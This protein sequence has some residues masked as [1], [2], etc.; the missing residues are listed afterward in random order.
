MP[1]SLPF[2]SL[3]LAGTTVCLA[4]SGLFAGTAYADEPA[5][6]PAA[7]AHFETHI[8]PLLAKRC[9]ECHG[10]E[11]QQGGVRLDRRAT[12]FSQGEL[13]AGGP[14]IVPG[15]A[16]GSRLIEV[17]AHGDYDTGM[18][19]A[20]KLPADEIALLT[21]WIER[22][23]VWPADAA[24]SEDADRSN[25]WS[26]RPVERPPVPEVAGATPIDRFLNASLQ[27]A[28]VTP[29]PR[30]DKRTQIR[31]AYLDMLGLPPTWDELQT[32]LADDSPDWWP[33]LIDRLLADQR[34]GPRWARHWLDVARYGDTR[35]YVFTDSIEYP[36]AWTYRDYVS[37]AFNEDKPFDRFVTEQLA[38][39]KL[40]LPPN[41][42][43]L[44]AL[45]FLTLGDKFS[46]NVMF[47][48]DDQVDV[49][50]R[51]L[52][53]LTVAC[54]R[55]HDHKFDPVPTEDYYALYGV[56]RSS[57][58]PDDLP[59]I[60]EPA[61]S[62]EVQAFREKRAE[63]E[64]AVAAEIAAREV[65]IEADLRKRFGQYLAAAGGL[66]P[67]QDPR[68]KSLRMPAVHH[69]NR[70]LKDAEPD[71]PLL[72][73]WKPLMANADAA[74]KTVV[75]ELIARYDAPEQG[76]PAAAADRWA[77]LPSGQGDRFANTKE[78][79]AI[80]KRQKAV[81]DFVA[82]SPHAPPR[83]HV[84]SD[85]SN[86]VR[87]TVFIR[88]DANRR[89]DEVVPHAIPS[90]LTDGELVELTDDP[91]SQANASG[92][93][94]LAAAIVDPGNP[95]TA[96]VIVNRVWGWHFGTG[97]VATPS[98]FGLQGD[99]PSHPDLL[100]WL[101]S[102]FVANGWSLKWLHRQ[103]LSTDAYRRVAGPAAG[104]EADPG[105]RLLGRFPRRRLSLEAWRDSVLHACGLLDPTA[106]G[107]PVDAFGPEPVTV[108]TI[109]AK[110]NR[111]DLPG[112]L[113]NFD[114]PSPDTSAAVRTETAVPQQAL[115]ALNGPHLAAWA[116]SLAE[117]TGPD[118]NELYRRV[119]LREPSDAERER[120][121]AFLDSAGADSSGA[122]SSGADRIALLAQALLMSNEFAFL[123]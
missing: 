99:R 88:G 119:L 87:N 1:A 46:K 34:M 107:R 4:L 72:G 20:A 55:C 50:S 63:L 39:D 95:L 94:E 24:T 91:R 30:A 75:E 93:R 9:V 19:P 65:S 123:E 71:D 106:E 69:F 76:A 53:G 49:V 18:P 74:D 42:P 10:P 54:A 59:Q 67:K 57:E 92:R 23:A 122:D 8:R 6:D 116:A 17:L 33:R 80:R 38:A 104:T 2:R 37:A 111:N 70:I 47:I 83:A 103:I 84:M 43:A 78:R 109:R 112:V 26:F 101:A 15:D 13:S 48:A 77:K 113:R 120:A 35:G 82:G 22:G 29:A 97:L 27:E 100:D 51:G 36:F 32:A 45:G 7:V 110:V 86:R 11:K 52:L 108:R 3:S 121:E 68:Y 81:T 96:R 85:R 114:F 62:P 40:N 102:E 58:E 16:K 44:A 66:L 5:P 115:Y 64:A 117:Q 31:R 79:N 28:G 105:N 12:A 73:E 98:D 56:F 60:G 61:D 21:A 118:V 25:H 41:D 14:A 90:I 89:G